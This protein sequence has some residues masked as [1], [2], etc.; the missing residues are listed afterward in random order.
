MPPAPLNIGFD[1]ADEA[2]LEQALTHR[3]AGRHNY[4]RLEFLG[5]AILSAIISQDLFERYPDAPEGDLSRARARLV[6]GTTLAQVAKER[7]LVGAI[8]L[9]SGE[10]K[11]GGQRRQSILADVLEAIIGAVY[12]E[13]GYQSCR[14][15]VL[16]WFSSRL[17]DM[18]PVDS[19]KDAKTRLQEYLQQR[20]QDLPHYQLV[21]TTGADH[22]RIFTIECQINSPEIRLTATGSSRRKAEQE[23]AGRVLSALENPATDQPGAG[24]E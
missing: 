1:F 16:D 3:S 15:L 21:N 2:L 22:A 5:D 14:T 24:D 11:S 23:A 12:L 7:G 19:L 8:R 13:G 4:E 20:G 17:D 18:P 9:G 6:R 10:K